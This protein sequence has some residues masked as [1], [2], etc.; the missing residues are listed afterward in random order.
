MPGF[1]AHD[2]ENV[3]DQAQ[4]VFGRMVRQGQRAAVHPPL[5]GAFDRQFEHADDGIHGGADF[6]A[7]SGQEGAFGAVGIVGL[8]LGLAQFRDQLAAVADVD[9]AADDAL[10]FTQR[11]TVG[12]DPVVDGH[13]PALDPQRAV[14]DQGGAGSHH[15]VV[16]RLDLPGLFG[17]GEQAGAQLFAD[18]LLGAGL[19]RLQVA[20]VAALQAAIAVAHVHGVRGAVEQCAHECQLVVQR[21]FGALALTDL[22]A[23][24]G[25]PEQR[26]QKQHRRGQYHLQR[27][28]A[29]ALALAVFV[30]AKAAPAVVDDTQFLGRNALQG[31]V[32]NRGQSR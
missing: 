15:F 5:I 25:V 8:L 23:Q 21:P 10:H 20:V 24:A 30:R 29:V 22:Q 9:P 12:Q 27:Q 6:V 2:I 18:N 32:E 1:D 3:T 16:I 26:Q 31:L 28:P 17:V 19:H 13:L 7:D 14:H 11:I 4:Q